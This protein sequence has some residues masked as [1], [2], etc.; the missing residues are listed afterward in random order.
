[1]K[2]YYLYTN[3]DG[4]S[5]W[6]IVF[7]YDD[8]LVFAREGFVE[9]MSLDEYIKTVDGAVAVE[10]PSAEQIM[11]Y[12]ETKKV[13]DCLSEYLNKIGCEL[14]GDCSIETNSLG[15]PISIQ[16]D[17]RYTKRKLLETT[18]VLNAEK[19]SNKVKK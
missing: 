19:G 12:N 13:C 10:I 17:A 8:S 9:P 7:T 11:K 16:V 15:Q 2:P 4:D 5:R 3:I 6:H 18:G 1:M 14:A